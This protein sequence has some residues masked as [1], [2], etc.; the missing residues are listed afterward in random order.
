MSFLNFR[1]ARRRAKKIVSL[2]HRAPSPPTPDSF[3]SAHAGEP[4]K[5]SANT[6]SVPRVDEDVTHRP[7]LA[8]DVIGIRDSRLAISSS[9]SQGGLVLV[10][11]SA[12]FS[13][14]LPD[15]VGSELRKNDA[16]AGQIVSEDVTQIPRP[17]RRTLKA[18]PAPIKI[19]IPSHASRVQIQRSAGK[20]AEPVGPVNPGDSP[21]HDDNSST[22]SGSTLPGAL[23]ANL[24]C[25][26]TDQS[27]DRHLSRR[28]TRLDSATLPTRDYTIM[29]D[30]DSDTSLVP[31]LRSVVKCQ[32]I[33]D[34]S[35]GQSNVPS[36]I[37]DIPT[38][39]D[40]GK[41]HHYSSP[42]SHQIS[43]IPELPTPNPSNPATP[44]LTSSSA[45]GGSSSQPQTSDSAPSAWSGPTSN[46]SPPSGE[47]IIMVLDVLSAPP[48]DSKLAPEAKETTSLPFQIEVPTSELDVNVSSGLRVP[49][50][51]QSGSTIDTCRAS[52]QRLGSRPSLLNDLILHPATL[53]SNGERRI[54]SAR[55]LSTSVGSARSEDTFSSALPSSLARVHS[56]HI[57]RLPSFPES[58][59][60]SSAFTSCGFPT[61]S[62]S[63]G[64]PS[65]DLLDNIFIADGS[66]TRL[67]KHHAF[68]AQ[69]GSSGESSVDPGSR[70]ASGVRVPLS[71]LSGSSQTFPETPSAYSPI[72][73][74]NVRST[75]PFPSSSKLGRRSRSLRGRS[76]RVSQKFLIGRSAT[77]KATVVLRNHKNLSKAKLS[78]QSSAKFAVDKA[79]GGS[80]S[81]PQ[82]GE[83]ITATTKPSEPSLALEPNDL[84]GQVFGDVFGPTSS[85]SMS[86]NDV[87]QQRIKPMPPAP[88]ATPPSLPL[89]PLPPPI[90]SVGPRSP[91]VP[92]SPSPQMIKLPPSPQLDSLPFSP[93]HGSG[94]QP[95]PP[96]LSE[97]HSAPPPCSLHT[98]RHPVVDLVCPPEAASTLPAPTIFCPSD[99]RKIPTR[100]PLPNGP[101]NPYCS[102]S[103]SSNFKSHSRLGSNSS[104]ESLSRVA[105]MGTRDRTNSSP[106]SGSSS[107]PK[108]QT[109]PTK[110]KVFTM[111][112]ARWTF[113]SDDLQAIVSTAIKQSAEPSFIRLL[114]T[115]AAFT[116]VPA[117][118]ERLAALQNELKVCYKL[119]VRKRDAL[120]RA[121]IT[122]AET[123]GSSSYALRARLQ[124]LAEITANLDRTAEELYHARDQASQLSRMLAVH[125]SSALMMALRKLHASYLRRVAE[126]KGLHEQVFTLEA[127]RDEAWAQAQQVA[128]DLDDLNEAL[129][130]RDSSPGA[131]R[132]LSR[133]SLVQASRVSSVRVSKAGLR[134]LRASMSSQ[135][136]AGRLSYVSV[137]TPAPASASD[138]IP[139]VPPFPRRLSSLNRIIT[140]DL[141]NRYSVHL[142]ELSSSSGARALAQA[143]ADLYGYLGIDDPDTRPSP[144]RRSSFVGSPLA[145]SPK[146]RDIPR[147]ISD[148]ADWRARGGSALDRFQAFSGSESDAILA[149]FHHLDD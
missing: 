45:D 67:S 12:G 109:S 48:P 104:L 33:N 28:I 20:S 116:D 5:R 121:A 50:T 92:A 94:P 132:P 114:T 18:T 72:F 32:A 95:P 19:P 146:A 64:P 145:A 113:T 34:L 84:R 99:A 120:H 137:G 71:A 136:G 24:W 43:P 9:D 4:T 122:C 69:P 35:K 39:E 131:S 53:L 119:Q 61:R 142:S 87:K 140:S 101:R 30:G 62:G 125:S 77:A 133:S 40:M 36:G 2:R 47:E 89:P 93:S 16:F 13:K 1:S 81:V 85:A 107:G 147:R 38:Q 22:V 144:L 139:P 82:C 25:V 26:Q 14:S 11:S 44:D 90:T 143:Q 138:A 73:S 130:T 3:V 129:R 70:L 148:S 108:F 127:E 106:G 78:R 141:S 134:S 6:S 68:F 135:V 42:I 29:R 91:F 103:G 65:P 124:E 58:A 54:S 49:H 21:V 41:P 98:P 7:L 88:L 75:R 110:V 23:I 10:G 100:P 59:A 117:E 80:S 56:H 115:Q 111:D 118:L 126:I 79:P 66:G 86:H 8:S 128:R 83:N 55:R 74:P 149:T 112:A 105:L 60:F 123:M 37:H 17:P 46:S 31:P 27:R 97:V 57:S 76:R 52:R 15:D 51:E 63:P 96:A 102:A